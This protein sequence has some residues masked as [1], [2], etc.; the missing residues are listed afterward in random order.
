MP[1]SGSDSESDLNDQQDDRLSKTVFLPNSYSDPG[2]ERRQKTQSIVELVT[3]S[4]DV[5][6]R[7]KGQQ[8]PHGV[9]QFGRGSAENAIEQEK[10]QRH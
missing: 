4:V 8:R 3:L 7:T 2:D 1:D 6:H 5:V 10:R 9:V